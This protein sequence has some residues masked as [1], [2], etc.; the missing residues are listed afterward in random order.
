MRRFT[1]SLF[2]G[3]RL[4]PQEPHSHL[5]C[6]SLLHFYFQVGAPSSFGT[7]LCGLDKIVILQTV[8]SDQNMAL[9]TGRAAEDQA[10][11]GVKDLQTS[12]ESACFVSHA[13]M[14]SSAWPRSSYLTGSRRAEGRTRKSA[15]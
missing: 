13:A 5:Y 6:R 4:R 9:G 8:H 7:C 12:G 2:P 3:K 10:A 11:A 15:G 14:S 1:Q